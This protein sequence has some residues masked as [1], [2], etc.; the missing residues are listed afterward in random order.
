M[1]VQMNFLWLFLTNYW[2]LEI[3]KNTS[4]KFQ[5]YIH[6]KKFVQFHVEY[7]ASCNTNCQKFQK[8]SSQI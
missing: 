5:K 7:K 1:S 2:L 8:N 6:I 3:T 4:L